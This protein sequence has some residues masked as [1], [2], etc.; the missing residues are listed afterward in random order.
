MSGSSGPSGWAGGGG[1]AERSILITHTNNSPLHQATL[2]REALN[3]ETLWRPGVCGSFGPR[4]WVGGDI[5]ERESGSARQ[6]DRRAEPEPRRL[7]V[8]DHHADQGGREDKDGRAERSN[9]IT[10][11]NSSTLH[12]AALN[13]ETRWR[14]GVSGSSGVRGWVYGGIS[15]ERE[16]GDDDG[17]RRP[18][19][20]EM[21]P[22]IKKA[23]INQSNENIKLWLSEV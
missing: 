10:R 19:L 15:T 18:P 12:R 6:E 2:N 5:T 14:P 11:T 17:N 1:P 7:L 13:R 3:R 21:E 8:E 20:V 4:G 16:S 9:L 23:I 22:E